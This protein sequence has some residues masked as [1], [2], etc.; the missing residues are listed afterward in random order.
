MESKYTEILAETSLKRYSE[1]IPQC[2]KLEVKI[3]DLNS[4]LEQAE[5]KIL[6]LENKLEAKT[7]GTTKTSSE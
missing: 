6:E 5:T 1:L 4:M 7:K 3:F 2:L